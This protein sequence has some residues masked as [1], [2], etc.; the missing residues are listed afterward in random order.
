MHID[1]CLARRLV[2]SQFPQWADLPLSPVEPEGWDHRTFRLGT[3]KS[4]RLPS[5]EAYSAQVA[6][7]QRW[8]PALA[9]QLPLPVPAPLVLGGPGEGYPWAWSIYRWLEGETAETA[10]VDDLDE[11]ATTLA[12]FLSALQRIDAV[13][14][15]PAGEHNFFRGGSLML[16]D[17][18]TRDAI[19][20]LA[21]R[22]DVTTATAVWE[23]AIASHWHGPPVWVHGDVSAANLLLHDGRL[24]AV[25]DFGSSGVGDPA[26]DMVVAWTLLSGNSRETFRR[27]VAVDEPTWARG[28]GWAL[29]KGLITLAG[30]PARAGRAEQTLQAVLADHHAWA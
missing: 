20:V 30:D 17:E 21:D 29:W 6:K 24:C 9:S 14:G 1:A 11:F 15:P 28:R 10:R 7:E 16:Y 12:D 3:D 27:A 2:D 13:D 5:A 25:I 26:C 22:I 8:L 23:A 19:S 4:V 18:E